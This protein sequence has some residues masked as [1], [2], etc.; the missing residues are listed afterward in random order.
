MESS[1][2][3]LLYVVCITTISRAF[4]GRQRHVC[5]D[6]L[7]TGYGIAGVFYPFLLPRLVEVFGLMGTFLVLGGVF[8]NVWIISILIYWNQPRKRTS[9]IP[10]KTIDNDNESCN[11]KAAN[12]TS[13]P[14]A[15]V[16]QKVVNAARKVVL[17]MREVLFLENVLNMVGTGLN[18]AAHNSYMTLQL[19][20][21]TW[22]G[23][24][25]EE[26]LN[27]ISGLVIALLIQ[28][29]GL[30][31]SSSALIGVSLG[32]ILA[33]SVIGLK[34]VRPELISLASGTLITMIGL[35]TAA[36]GPLLGYFRDI[37][38]DYNLVLYITISIHVLTVIL[39]ITAF[40]TRR[41]RGNDVTLYI[42]PDTTKTED[43]CL[44]NDSKY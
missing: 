31:Y 18:M 5:L 37:A 33:S 40:M 10:D 15:L 27:V 23:L 36:F 38:S 44:E 7:S 24:S 43:D 32:G 26:G 19:D 29:P 12:T 22:R 16:W 39:Y 3:S 35:L 9:A 21:A 17:E 4:T 34:I 13:T 2:I 1:G 8:L 25:S 14:R 30:S 28:I 42:T 41:P 6:I 11:K 20:I